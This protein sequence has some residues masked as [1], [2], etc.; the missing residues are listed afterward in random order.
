MEETDIEEIASELADTLP[1]I[2]LFRTN[3]AV[4]ELTKVSSVLLINFNPMNTPLNLKGA[5]NNTFKL[6]KQRL[7]HTIKCIELNDLSDFRPEI[8]DA[9]ARGLTGKMAPPVVPVKQ[10]YGREVV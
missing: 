7:E 5:Y 2:I 10:T 8:I 6:L 3:L 1:R 9:R 4:D